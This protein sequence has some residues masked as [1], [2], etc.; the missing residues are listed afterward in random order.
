VGSQLT[1]TEY[2][3]TV[4]RADHYQ[5]RQ[6]RQIIQSLMPLMSERRLSRPSSAVS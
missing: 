4:C 1:M 2:V 6:L 5:L 3:T